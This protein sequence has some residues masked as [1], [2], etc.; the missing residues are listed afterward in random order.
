MSGMW[1]C[2][3]EDWPCV[4]NGNPPHGSWARCRDLRPH[5]APHGAYA[6]HERARGASDARGVW[7]SWWGARGWHRV[8]KRDQVVLHTTPAPARQR[9][10][11]LKLQVDPAPGCYKG[12]R[13]RERVP[14]HRPTPRKGG[15]G[16][17]DGVRAAGI[18]Y[19]RDVCR[20][21]DS[22]PCVATGRGRA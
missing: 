21:G 14:N 6:R 13:A 20:R 11:F 18:V 16:G 2:I 12:P 8:Y 10:D 1:S 15:C 17:A 22:V 5:T 4:S 7:R 9:S 3:S 19:I